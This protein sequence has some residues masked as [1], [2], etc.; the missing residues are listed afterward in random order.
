MP[1]FAPSALASLLLG[2]AVAG[3]ADAFAGLKLIKTNHAP[4]LRMV[5]SILR[6]STEVLF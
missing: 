3:S 6:L 4:G 5:G 1:K 2:A